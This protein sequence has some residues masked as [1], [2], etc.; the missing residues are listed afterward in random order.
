MIVYIQGR[1]DGKWCTVLPVD[2]ERAHRVCQRLM[3]HSFAT[4]FRIVKNS[5]AD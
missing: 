3:L 1:I 5:E 2:Q 4:E